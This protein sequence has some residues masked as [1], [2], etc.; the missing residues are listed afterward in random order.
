MKNTITFLLSVIVPLVIITLVLREAREDHEKLDQLREQTL[1]EHKPGVDHSKLE[2]L[3][4]D[5]SNPH[6]ITA[7]CLS[8]HTERGHELLESFHFTWE[9]EEY[10]E[11]RGVTYKGK[12]N[13]INNFCTGIMTN[14]GSCNRCHAGYGW[15]DKS[16]DFN[17]PY[18]IDC[19]VCHD[20]TGT[21]E[22]GRGS[23]GYPEQG[24]DLRSIVQNVG[25]PTSTNCGYCH[26]H[27]GGGNNVK[28]GDLEMALLN[29]NRQVDVHMAADGGNMHCTHCHTATNHQVSGRYYGVS[30]TNSRRT[31]C[32]QC[33]TAT[34]HQNHQLNTHVV[35]IACQTCHIPQYAKV[36]PTKMSWDWSTAGRTKDGKPYEEMDEQGNLVYQSIKGDADWQTNVVPEYVWFNGTADHLLMSD[37]ID[38]TAAYTR[39]NTL[40]GSASDVDSRIIPIK[41]HRGRQPFDPVHLNILQAKL[42]DSEQGKGALW[43]DLDWERA[44]EEGMKYVGRPYSGQWDFVN[45][46]MYL[47]VN[48]MVSPVSEALTCTDCHTRTNSRMQYVEGV[49][50]PSSTTFA[51]LDTLGVLLIIVSLVG[52]VIHAIIRVIINY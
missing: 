16:F 8:C 24:Q 36:N 3:Q 44:L 47:P 43:L 11:G 28:H 34:P 15:A 23:A 6:E 25:L 17:N 40:F 12:K 26:F 4:Q 46:E 32:E 35:K 42:W 41:V 50:I 45:T 22:K 37:R 1:L 52:V 20:N 33:H 21:Y 38:T 2:I 9:R 27:G 51:T 19:L 7:A 48:H 18:N 31:T 30:S 29:T 10:I 49:Y 39:I 14:E 13:L 5:F